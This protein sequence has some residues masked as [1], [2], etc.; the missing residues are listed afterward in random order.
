[1]KNTHSTKSVYMLGTISILFSILKTS[2]L[3][4]CL[5][6]ST[7]L[8]VFEFEEHTYEIVKESL[9]WVDA[10]ACAVERGG[11]LTEINSQAE[12]DSIYNAILLA[13][14]DTYR[15]IAPDGGGASYIWIG[16]N[17][18]AVNEE[19]I[20]DGN[21]D[22]IGVQFWQGDWNGF[23]VDSLYNNWGGEPDIQDAAA[24][25][26]TNWIYGD[27][28]EWND[29]YS[30]NEL[31]YIIER[32]TIIETDSN[33]TTNRPTNQKIVT[34]SPNP[35]NTSISINFNVSLLAQIRD[36][37]V[38]DLHG[39]TINIIKTNFN[40][41]DISHL[42]NGIHFIQTNLNNNHSIVEKLVKN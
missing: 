24:I 18:F 10:A 37:I 28:G 27:A 2:L 15:T 12:Q 29:V 36:V 9:N 25:A 35:A 3:S 42:P 6:D 31:Y 17:D 26:L 32:D 1:M 22:G 41:I 16:A 23:S 39:K 38:T 40:N 20:W 21:N 5:T 4:Q 33:D 7:N 11:Y 8:L 19:W 30:T 34:V 14:I 13:D